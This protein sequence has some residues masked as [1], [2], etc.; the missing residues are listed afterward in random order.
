MTLVP[1]SQGCLSAEVFSGADMPPTWYALSESRVGRGGE[2][3]LGWE[4]L[5]HQWP[6]WVMGFSEPYS[7]WP[8]YSPTYMMLV[9]VMSQR[10]GA[11][12]RRGLKGC[13]GSMLASEYLAALHRS[14]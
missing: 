14:R 10:A 3:E 4:W 13:W 12:K 2:D 1:E 8:G 11:R 6:P 7:A 5:F 9:P